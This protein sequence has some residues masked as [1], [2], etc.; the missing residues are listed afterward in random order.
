MVGV[1]RHV[2]CNSPDHTHTT[3]TR[4]HAR[5]HAF[6]HTQSVTV[7]SCG[8]RS[9]ASETSPPTVT[10]L[11]PSSTT[12]GAGVTLSATVETSSVCPGEKV[13]KMANCLHTESSLRAGA[14]SEGHDKDHDTD[15]SL[16][17]G[18]EKKGHDK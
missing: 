9:E 4:T 15:S 14:D 10:I 17:V 8:H 1:I 16:H 6:T 7:F 18:A 5:T 12:I 13:C 3:H 11:A 2:W